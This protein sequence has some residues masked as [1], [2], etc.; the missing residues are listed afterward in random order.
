[1]TWPS[2]SG[3]AAASAGA[4]AAD[5]SPPPGAGAAGGV[6]YTAVGCG[7]ACAAAGT[8]RLIRTFSSPSVISSSA[9]PDCC[10]RSI[11]VL[12]LRKSMSVLAG[13]IQR[14]SKCEAV[15]AGA[16]AGHDPDS[17]VAQVRAPAEL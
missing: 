3:G 17:E 16:Q 6:M 14:E 5:G 7:E 2:G 11:R 13:V 1:M 8:P 4:A 12:S 15:T 9:M 10:T